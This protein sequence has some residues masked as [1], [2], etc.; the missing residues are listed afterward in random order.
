MHEKPKHCL[1]NWNDM[2]PVQ[3]G[4]HCLKCQHFIKDFT[5][6][7]WEEIDQIQSSV[8]GP[9]CGI[10]TKK[11]IESW[12][13]ASSKRKIPAQNLLSG[14]A[15][16]SSSLLLSNGLQAQ[17]PYPQI[18]QQQILAPQDLQKNPKKEQLP[19]TSKEDVILKGKVSTKEDSMPLAGVMVYIKSLRVLGYTD[20]NGEFSL[21]IPEGIL[22]ETSFTITFNYIG[23]E[24]QEI[25]VKNLEKRNFDIYL[26]PDNNDLAVFYIE[27]PPLH[28]RVWWKIKGIFRK[29]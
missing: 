10:Y 5:K 4:R 23:Y 27:L 3:G 20:E 11:Q 22:H 8:E 14:M 29:K 9:Y 17:N 12:G 24:D 19:S 25:A 13:Q 26:T 18:P 2:L 6:K 1:E 7:S 15:M 16:L 21:I 28:K